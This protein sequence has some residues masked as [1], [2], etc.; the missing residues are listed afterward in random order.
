MGVGQ[1]LRRLR[2][3]KGFTQTQLAEPRYSHAYVSAI[4]AGRRPPTRRA[5]EHFAAKLDVDPDELATGRPPDL[6]LRLGVE[7][8][9]ARIAVSDG[10]AGEAQSVFEKVATKAAR[11]GLHE[12]VTKAYE[13]LA[14]CEERRARIEEAIDLYDRS[15]EISRAGSLLGRVEAVVGKA[16]CAQMQGDNR[17]AIYL[18]ESLLDNLEAEGLR[19]PGAI[20]RIQSALVRPY[21]DSGL[22][23]KANESA[24]EALLLAPRVSDPIRIAQM[25]INVLSVLVH[26]GDFAAAEASLDRAEELY[27]L[28]SLQTEIGRAFLA[29]GFTLIREDRLAEARSQLQ[30][31]REIF[32]QT[33]SPVD[34]ARTLNEIAR[35]ERLSD[36]V[37]EAKRHLMRAMSLLADSD[38]A[39]L[40]A[41]HYELAMCEVETDAVEAEKHLRVSIELFQR[42]EDAVEIAASYRVLGDLL[43]DAGNEPDGCEAYR[44]GLLVL[45][46]RL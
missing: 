17:Y 26:R 2:T 33:Q 18:L 43:H 10:R 39:E 7:L 45:E 14:L 1:R 16:R 36:N 32:E 8:H 13:G 28:A 34:E 29:R 4:E 40:A 9:E 37:V 38:V 20:L 35:L 42:A 30:S 5:I 19:E 25:H 15:I 27:R 31:A 21:F 12:L 23:K 22:F 41:A 44:T 6:G 46:E 24:E 11:H 3:A